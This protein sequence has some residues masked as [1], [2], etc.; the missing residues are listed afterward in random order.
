MAWDHAFSFY[1]EDNLE[2]LREQ[3]VEIVRFSPLKDGS[4]PVGVIESALDKAWS[5]RPRLWSDDVE[6]LFD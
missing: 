2:L 6:A 5:K 4:L 3:G 1:Y